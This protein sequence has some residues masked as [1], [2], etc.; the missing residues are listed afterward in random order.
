MRT[1]RSA[2]VFVNGAGIMI[3]CRMGFDA[4][5]IN[6][7]QRAIPFFLAALL[8]LNLLYLFLTRPE[9]KRN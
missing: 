6:A 4:R 3:A 2:L 5:P 7:E 8:A 1:L 9:K